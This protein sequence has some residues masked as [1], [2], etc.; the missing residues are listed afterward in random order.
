MINKYFYK[1]F[2]HIVTQLDKDLA[3]VEALRIAL[4]KML[5][6]GRKYL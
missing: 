6:V 5:I 2:T 1:L 4:T 3:Q